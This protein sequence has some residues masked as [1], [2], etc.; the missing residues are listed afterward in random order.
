[1][2]LDYVTRQS[3]YEASDTK[4]THL[5]IARVDSRP[6][7]QNS[8]AAVENRKEIIAPLKEAVERALTAM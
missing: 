4:K 5:H 2:S 7:H 3:A 6:V 8:T 1:M